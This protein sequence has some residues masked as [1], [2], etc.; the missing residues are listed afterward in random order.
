M[1]SS[2]S[3]RRP[4]GAPS[5]SQVRPRTPNIRK[6]SPLAENRNRLSPSNARLEPGSATSALARIARTRSNSGSSSPTT[7]GVAAEANSLQTPITNSPSAAP[8]QARMARSAS[9]LTII[10]H[11]GR[12]A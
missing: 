4:T 10:F 2:R 6:L 9:A 12:S 5:A 7:G 1:S 8:A 11:Q 3:S